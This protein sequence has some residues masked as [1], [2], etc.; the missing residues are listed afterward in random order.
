M[1]ML[2]GIKAFEACWQSLKGTTAS[3]TDSRLL[4]QAMGQLID[5]YATHDEIIQALPTAL[6]EAFDC[7]VDAYLNGY[8][9]DESRKEVPQ[10]PQTKIQTSSCAES[11][12]AMLAAAQLRQR[13]KMQP[14]EASEAATYIVREP[15]ELYSAR[16]AFGAAF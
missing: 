5:N 11:S 12:P 10:K 4:M 6:G 9:L 1:T 13:R 7:L 16:G 15:S 8:W 2:T 3:A 14:T